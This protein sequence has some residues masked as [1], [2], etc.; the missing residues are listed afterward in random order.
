MKKEVAM[1]QTNKAITLHGSPVEV[2]G[3]PLK[4]GDTLPAFTLSNTDLQDIKSTDY[5]GKVLVISVIPSI[6]TPVC[7][8]QTRQF[9]E[10]IDSL[11]ENVVVLTV[12]RDLPFAQKRWCAAEGIEKVVCASDY[13]YRSFGKAFGV[14]IENIGLLARAVFVADASGKLVYVDYVPEI[15]EEP[16]YDEVKKAVK[17]CL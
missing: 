1:A 17:D 10:A 9:N 15:S 13:K 5:S 3:T 2:S 11:S 4:V 8:V 14:D 16:S 12:S 7:Q 6:D